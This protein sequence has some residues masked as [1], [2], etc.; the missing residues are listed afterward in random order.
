[1]LSN[2]VL[3]FLSTLSESQRDLFLM[4][5][6]SFM[7]SR[8]MTGL[9]VSTRPTSNMPRPSGKAQASSWMSGAAFLLLRG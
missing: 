6:S 1:M 2:V 9:A 8:K 7:S 3:I 5:M 4:L